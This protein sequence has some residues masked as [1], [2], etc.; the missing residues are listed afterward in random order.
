MIRSF[1]F[2]ALFLCLALMGRAQDLSSFQYLKDKFQKE[3]YLA[4]SLMRTQLFNPAAPDDP[5][6]HAKGVNF[7]DLYYFRP[8]CEKWG[9]NRRVD[10]KLLTD[11]AWLFKTITE[12]DESQ[13]YARVGSSITGG[14]IGWHSWNWN[15][16]AKPKTCIGAGLSIND[17][18]IG[19]IYQNKEKNGIILQE[20]QGWQIAAGPS[21]SISHL[22]NESFMLMG[23]ASYVAS[24]A[25]PVDVSYAKA[26]NKYPKPHFA[27]AQVTLMSKWGF[28]AETQYVRLINRGA[29]RNSTQRVDVKLGFALVL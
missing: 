2:L 3:E 10:Y 25:K 11:M 4:F 23:S 17:Y 24:F 21:G 22:L 13:M 29:N 14:I 26:D 16:Q 9:L 19:A 28:F 12:K 27:H 20:P 8:N 15:L 1:T 5:S 7:L 18:F 6:L